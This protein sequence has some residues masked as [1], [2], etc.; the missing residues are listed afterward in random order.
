M[1]AK[2]KIDPSTLPGTKLPKSTGYKDK[3]DVR[4]KIE[5]WEEKNKCYTNHPVYKWSPTRD[6]LII[7]MVREGKKQREI[8]DE[9]GVS[10]QSISKHI[11]RLRR[12]GVDI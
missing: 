10:K 11:Q 9:L 8:A 12:R 6:N 3:P 2:P 7:Q 4:S 1:T 5:T